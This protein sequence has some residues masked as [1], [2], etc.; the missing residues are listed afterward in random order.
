MLRELDR[1]LER[2]RQT[3]AQHDRGREAAAEPAAPGVFALGTH[4]LDLVTGRMGVVYDR[5][6][7]HIIVPSSHGKDD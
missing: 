6:T 1:L 3:R 5:S 7:T 4:V 2:L